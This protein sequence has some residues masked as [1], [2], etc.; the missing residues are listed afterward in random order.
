MKI[1]TERLVANIIGFGKFSLREPIMGNDDPTTTIPGVTDGSHPGIGLM[2][3]LLLIGTF[4][5]F[6]GWRKV[7]GSFGHPVNARKALVGGISTGIS[8]VAFG[9]LCLLA[10][11]SLWGVLLL[12]GAAALFGY[13]AAPVRKL[14]A[15]M[16][17]HSTKV[18]PEPPGPVA[19][20]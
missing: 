5:F 9:V 8:F 19:H 10:G 18:P 11:Q 6:Y 13:A 16:V 12:V 14:V 2:V 17:H 4:A 7:V 1:T 15:D 3:V 20:V